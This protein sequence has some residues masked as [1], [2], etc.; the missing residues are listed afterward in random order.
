LGYKILQLGS[1]L[2]VLGWVLW[3]K[4]KIASPEHLLAA[5]LS[6]W[7]SWQ[8]LFGPGT[9]QITYGIIAPSAAWAVMTSFEKRQNGPKTAAS[10]LK[11]LSFR[12]WTVAAWLILG[13]FA[14]GDIE[15]PLAKLTPAATMLLPLGAVMFLMWLVIYHL[16]DNACDCA[17]D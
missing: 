1:A 8:L 4:R 6:I 12:I 11:T 17:P 3:Q 7:A 9:E 15:K 16:N 2:A 10:R 5:I 13:L 14:M